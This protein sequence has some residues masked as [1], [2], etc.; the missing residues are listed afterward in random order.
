MMVLSV[1]LSRDSF[2]IASFCSSFEAF[3]GTPWKRNTYCDRAGSY[4][5]RSFSFSG[6]KGFS[7]MKRILPLVEP[8]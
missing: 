5:Y 1:S 7:G 2:N 6:H 8:E 3:S 4:L